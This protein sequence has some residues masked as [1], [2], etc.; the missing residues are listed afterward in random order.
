MVSNKKVLILGS[1]GR[2]GEL[3]K[4]KYEKIQDFD[5]IGVSSR[6]VNNFY[7]CKATN[8]RELSEFL[9]LHEPDLIINCAAMTNVDKCE[10]EIEK[11]FKANKKIPEYL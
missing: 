5:V 6:F 3:I 11:A 10:L 4:N 9:I 1:T 8:N 2:L 7:H